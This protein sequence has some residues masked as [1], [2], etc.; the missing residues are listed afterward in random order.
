MRSRSRTD[1]DL[2]KRARYGGR[3]VTALAILVSV[4]AVL[5]L[6]FQ[7]IFP[8]S[9]LLWA[10][11]TL[12]LIAA[13]YWML[14]TVTRQGETLGL[15][16][17]LCLMGFQL[18]LAVAGLVLAHANNRKTTGMEIWW[19]I[20]PLLIVI[21]LAGNRSDLLELH[22]RGL[23]ESVFGPGRPPRILTV[24]GGVLLVGAQIALFAALLIPAISA[25]RTARECHDFVTM[26]NVHDK[27]LMQIINGPDRA[28]GM[29]IWGMASDAADQL[30]EQARQVDAKAPE[31]SKLKSITSTYLRAIDRWCVAFSEARKQGQ[32]SPESAAAVN[33]GDQLR[34][35]AL[36]EFQREFPALAPRPR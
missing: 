25:A 32:M 36:E 15:S 29:Q 6:P 7:F 8:D 34:Q 1:E 21:A 11:I 3:N 17:I 20:I 28:S 22:R 14:A 13:A 9:G 27:A 35:R 31:G 2:I 23:R 18:L 4:P 16:I 19:V 5:V 10:T 33:E 24:M 30:R 26:I 12:A